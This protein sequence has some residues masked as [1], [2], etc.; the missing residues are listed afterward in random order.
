MSVYTKQDLKKMGYKKAFIKKVYKLPNDTKYVVIN[1]L[2]GGE[3]GQYRSYGIRDWVCQA[4]EW[5]YM[6]N[7]VEDNEYLLI[8]S[9]ETISE[10]WSIE[11]EETQVVIDHYNKHHEDIVENVEKY[12]DFDKVVNFWCWGE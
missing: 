12:E 1:D 8:D 2:Q 10:V 6:D 7:L 11:F 3:F 9:L 5:C 4:L